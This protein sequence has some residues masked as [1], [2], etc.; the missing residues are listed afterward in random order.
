MLTISRSLRIALGLFVLGFLSAAL[1][2][3]D[4]AALG[5]A[6]ETVTVARNL[7]AGNG[8][9][10]PYDALATGSTTLVPPVHPAIMAGVL[11]LFGYGG[12]FTAVL[13][14]LQFVLNGIQAALLPSVSEHLLG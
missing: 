13:V 12:T 7:A 9:S 4:D 2:I 1:Q 10:S 5:R 11:L 3:G 14:L 6:F 8:F